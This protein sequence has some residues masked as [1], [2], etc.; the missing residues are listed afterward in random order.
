MTKETKN[1][2][3]NFH[4]S[5]KTYLPPTIVDQYCDD[6]G[7]LIYCLSNGNTINANRYNSLWRPS[8]GVIDWKAKGN[9]IDN[10]QR[11]Y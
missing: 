1:G 11:L 3:V 4:P 8:K 6:N 5:V 2:A 10:K 7:E 9:R